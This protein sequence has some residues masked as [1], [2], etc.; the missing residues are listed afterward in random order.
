[1]QTRSLKTLTKIAQTESFSAAAQALNMTLST[2]SMQMNALEKELGV[3]LFDRSFRPP[4]LTPVGRA[5]CQHAQTLIDEEE[6]LLAACETSDALTGFYRIGFVPTASIRLLP[7]FLSAAREREEAAHFDIETGLS[8][9]LSQRVLAG[10]LDAAIITQSGEERD[11]LTVHDLRREPIVYAVPLDAMA[12]KDNAAAIEGLFQRL[13][14]L[15][16]MPE[17]GIGALIE[18]RLKS[19]GLRPENSI[20]LDSVEAIMECVN[21]GL[22][23]T[24]L[25]KP[26]IERYQ[27]NTTAIVDLADVTSFRKLVLVVRDSATSSGFGERLAAL[28]Q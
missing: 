17:S 16:F 23:F 12:K 1:M 14:F 10:D 4:R 19:Q 7:A 8:E 24:L 3:A 27:S 28:F 18:A 21:E 25:P 2:V 9:A 22:G 5:V 11:G 6:A 26:D 20:Y 13:P 15:H